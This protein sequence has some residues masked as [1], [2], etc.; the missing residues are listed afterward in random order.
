MLT[1]FQTIKKQ[2]R[3]LRELEQGAR[4][5]EFENYTKKE[6]LLFERERVK[7]TRN[8][9]GIK[10]MGRLPGALFVVDA[11]EGKDRG[12]RRPTSSA[13]RWSPSWTPTPIRTSSRC[14][15]RATTTRSASVSLITGALCDVIKRSP[16]ADARCAKRRRT[17]RPRPTAPTRGTEGDVDAERRKRRPAPQAAAQAGGDRGPARSTRAR[18]RRAGPAGEPRRVSAGGVGTRQCEPPA[19]PPPLGAAR[20]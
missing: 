9:E 17:P 11:Q 15:F 19:S 12:R 7:L 2:I 1:N 14:R 4:D 6:K 5:G 13:S 8:L 18:R 20:P 3:R 10:Q 16:G